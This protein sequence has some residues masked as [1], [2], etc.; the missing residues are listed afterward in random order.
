MLKLALFLHL[1]QPPTQFPEITKK[2][3]QESYQKI[4]ES[5]VKASN[6]HLT[7]NFSVSLAEQLER[8]G[9]EKIVAG[10]RN[11]AEQKK[12]ELTASAAY[13]PLLTKIPDEEIKRQIKVNDELSQKYFGPVWISQNLGFF[14]PEMAYS[15]QVGKIL[16][17]RGFKWVILEESA[18]SFKQMIGSQKT[19]YQKK[20]SDHL[21]FFFR[22]RKLSLAVAFATITNLHELFRF[23]ETQRYNLD[24]DSYLVI[25]MD[26]E[27]FGHHQ[28]QQLSFLEELLNGSSKD[29]RLKLVTI[30]DLFN[31]FPVAGEIEPKFSTWGESFDRWDNPQN[32][33]HRLQWQLFNLALKVGEQ[34]TEEVHVLLDRAIH[35]DQFWWASHHP[36]WHPKMVERG[37]KMLQDVVLK[38]STSELEKNQAVS[39]YKEIILNGRQLYGEEMVPC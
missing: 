30:S 3:S 29:Q 8:V 7:V 15:P 36:C 22:D 9:L 14:P 38:S 39:L 10:F 24:E 11:L 4:L 19:I 35:S 17:E 27:T 1:Y 21:S 16:E 5:L 34:A 18:Q 6:G 20:G 33:I 26:G 2:I 31:F 28:P 37:A 32:P 12:I 13:H 25:A 23:F